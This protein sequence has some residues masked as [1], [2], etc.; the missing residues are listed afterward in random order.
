ME[1]AMNLGG[2]GVHGGWTGVSGAG[3]VGRGSADVRSGVEDLDE[4]WSSRPSN[5]AAMLARIWVDNPTMSE[6]FTLGIDLDREIWEL[7]IHLDGVD[8]L[9]RRLG[10]DDITLMNLYALIETHG[11]SFS[12]TIYR[13][14]GEGMVIIQNNAQ[15]YELLEQYESTKVLNLIAKRGIPKKHVAKVVANADEGIVG[16]RSASCIINYVDPVVYDLSPPPVYAFDGEGTIFPSQN[17]YFATQE[18][19]NDA[20]NEK[21]KGIPDLNEA[22][23]LD[24]DFDMG[25]ADFN[26]MEEM[27]RKEQAEQPS[28]GDPHSAG[29]SAAAS[30]P[31]PQAPAP[32]ASAPQTPRQAS[33]SQPAT[34]APR[35]CDPPA[36]RTTFF[37]RSQLIPPRQA[38]IDAQEPGPAYKRTMTWGYLNYGYVPNGEEGGST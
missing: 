6:R 26:M 9:E 4:L 37:P 3:A 8:N 2:G 15:I 18:S 32:Q 12:D 1:E 29:P 10:Y 35:Q 27:R 23:N 13:R 36:P 16:S 5:A 21:G 24:M 17:S 31:A 28:E 22:G 14:K 25:E 33:A 20:G 7:R 11:F 30:Q 19:R 34:Q 38:E